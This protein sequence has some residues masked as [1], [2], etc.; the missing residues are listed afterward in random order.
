MIDFAFLGTATFWKYASMPVI[1][2]VIGYVTNVVAIKM[3]F[4]PIEFF[5]VFKPYLGWQGIVPRKAAKMSA[6]ATDT[7]TRNLI[8]S[9]E[10]FA[11]LDPDAVARKLSVP[12]NELAAELVDEVMTTHHPDIWA[13]TPKSAR[14]TIVA[15]VQAAVPQAIADTVRDLRTDV[16]QVFDLKDMVVTNL[17]HHKELMNRIFL[18]TGDKE[19]TFIA[20]SGA[21]FGFPLGVIQMIVWMFYQPWWLLPAFGLAVGYITNWAALKMIFNPKQKHA[22]GPFTLHGLFFKRQR[23]VARAYGDLV[24]NEVL[25]PKNILQQVL[26]GPYSDRIFSIIAHRV[27]EAIDETAGI[28]RPFMTWTVGDLNYI[29]LKQTAVNRLIEQ[30]PDVHDDRSAALREFM[31]YTNETMAIETTLVERMREL[32][33]REFEGMLR[34]AFEEDEWILITVGAVLGLMVGIFQFIVLFGGGA[35]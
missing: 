34:P 19:F 4:H 16:N 15:R 24:A 31:E 14:D 22:V 2:A 23:D 13:R 28:A 18:E 20:R 12:L 30:T 9:E 10:I 26:K 17:V 1:S 7:I 29:Q 6:I 11:R 27:G 21:Y 25:S 35:G 33:P 8:D 3:M 32:P 5:G